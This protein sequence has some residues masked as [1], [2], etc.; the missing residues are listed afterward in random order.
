MLVA[1]GQTTGGIA[2]F[3]TDALA[4]TGNYLIAV[5][6]KRPENPD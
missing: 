5:R 4:V 2:L 1:T 6:G 3:V